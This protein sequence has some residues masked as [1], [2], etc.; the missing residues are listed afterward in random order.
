MKKVFTMLVAVSIVFIGYA[1]ALAA[2]ATG[3]WR[4]DGMPD[5]VVII[6]QDRDHIYIAAQH[7]LNGQPAAV[8]SYGQGTIEGNKIN[9]TFKVV[10]RPNSNWGGTD[11]ITQQDLTISADSKVISGT[12]KNDVGQGTA[13]TLRRVH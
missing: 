4:Y 10:R 7:A 2:D 5:S 11:G 3:V 1:I 9:I 8:I 13:A 6:C 12:W